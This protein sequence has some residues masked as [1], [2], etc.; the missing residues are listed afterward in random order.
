MSNVAD[1]FSPFGLNDPSEG[2]REVIED[3]ENLDAS[4]NGWIDEDFN[5]GAGLTYGNNAQ[6]GGVLQDGLYR[7]AEN[8]E[9]NFS[10]P[11]TP[12]EVDPAETMKAAVT[13]IFYTVNMLH[14]LYYVLGWTPAAGNLQKDNGDEGGKGNDQV[15]I[16]V[17]YWGDRNNGFMRQTADGIAP[18]MTMLLFNSTDP[19]RDVAF[20]N[21][22]VI[23]EYTHGCRL[24][25]KEQASRVNV[26]VYRL[27]R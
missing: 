23:H 20:D 7:W 2:E 10:F 26:V 11:Y 27:T 15:D 25:D 19:M 21:G 16:S 12:D 3:P 9:L 14:D 18:S 1:L 22:F 4:K 8:K 13:N 24:K 17:Q 5:N 6:A